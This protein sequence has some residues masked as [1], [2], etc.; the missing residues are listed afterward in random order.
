MLASYYRPIIAVHL[1]FTIRLEDC[2]GGTQ[3]GYLQA[4]IISDL[5][6]GSG[7]AELP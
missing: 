3:Q 6:S 1:G 5:A 4:H 7:R 2:G